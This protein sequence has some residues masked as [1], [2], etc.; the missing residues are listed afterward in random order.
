MSEYLPIQAHYHAHRLTVAG[1]AEDAFTRS[2]TSARV[3][4]NPHQVD[5]ALFA[6]K[7]PY[8]KGVLLAD[9]VGLGKTIEAGLVMSQKWAEQKQ[10]ILLV[11]PA[12]LRKQWQQELFDKFSLRSH[13]LEA[14][15]YNDLRKAG[16]TRPFEMGGGILISS[17]EFAARKAD[18]IRAVRWDL[19]VFDEAHR[20]RNVHR[21]NTAK[22]AKALKQATDGV[23]K[24]LLT[25]T[26]LQ[27][28]LMELFGI[29]S[30]ID[31]T[32]FGGENAFRAQYA[33]AATTPASQEMLRE[34]LTPICHRT[35][36]RQVQ[37]AGHINFRQ[38]NAVTFQFEPYDQETTLYEMLSEYL[39]DPG[40]IA[41]G[42]R[43][44]ALVVLQ[45]RKS[46]GSST[47][48]VARYLDTLLERLRRKQAAS[49]D[50]TDDFEDTFDEERE[51]FNG[52]NGGNDDADDFVDPVQLANE[53]ALV[54]AMRD[55]A[56]EIGVNAK[57]E[58]LIHN[59]PEVLDQIEA[60]GGRRKAV[61]FTE[62]VRTQKYLSQL[63][64]DNGYAGQIVLMNGSNNDDESRAIYNAWKERHAGTDRISGSKT[65][66]MKA[67]IVE[68]FRSDDK[69]ILIATESGAEGINL[70]F[71]SLLINYDLPW[72][73]Q[74]VEQRIGRCHR[75]G[76]LVD[77]MVVNMLN[78]K[79]R[80]EAR[81]H[82]L[83]EQKLHLFEGVF[84]SSDEVL[85]I[86]T[87]GIDFEKEVLRI[88]QSCRSAE[89]ADR[90][91]DELTSRIQ[92][93]IDTDLA[94]ARAKVLENMD[95]D[96]VAKLHR[97]NEALAQILPEFKQRLLMVAK[98]ELPDAQFPTPDSESFGWG[99]KQ[100]T[101]K[102]PLADE[103]DWQFFRVNEGLGHDLIERAKDRAVGDGAEAVRFDPAA[104]AYAGQLG[105]V[106]ALSGQSGWLRAFRAVM[107][108]PGAEREEVIVIA[109]TDA[110]EMV[111]PQVCDKMMMAPAQSLGRAA[112]DI[113]HD[114]LVQLQEFEFGHFSERV[115]QENYK[116]LIDEEERLGRYARD[117][118]I[119]IEAQIA[120]L[121][122]E[123]KEL[124]R[125]KIS[126]HLGME[127]KVTVMRDI[128]KK[129]TARDELKMSQFDAKKQV[130]KDIND[131]L[132]AF[133]ALLDE[134]PRLEEMFTLRWTVA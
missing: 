87:D 126:P 109:E 132:D 103:N 74:R 39:Q 114:R 80:A 36:R 76:Q 9:E 72:N 26:P 50:M 51:T 89:E 91:F 22:G 96:V 55:L 119:E 5:A 131:K 57:G 15:T 20:L 43:T 46:L 98:A 111:K 102:W 1:T 2:L 64:T 81:I 7:A 134:Q 69:A 107:P 92:D 11:V 120:A 130:S 94:A 49:P 82:Q 122:V 21:N 35:L 6:L 40:T 23:F 68:A 110:G 12:S 125:Q 37:E 34:R 47:F 33:G 127:E 59:L 63:L 31:D 129:E 27:N 85:G 13:I 29:V 97:R 79:N 84:G 53:I 52:D 41:Y 48:A 66:D 30:M 123:L 70:Q 25:A 24:I 95:A 62:S 83:L 56:Q 105:G 124:Q 133:S 42:G 44:N 4:M 90:E 101:T 32:H 100:W 3:E 116:W 75:Y 19:V 8:A 104:Y 118:E 93:S 67:A 16:K 86:L 113:P 58:K 108:T 77:V 14:K 10:R 65:A 38:R 88:V 60:K 121:D 18:E 61:I 128:R 112:D 54:E 115:K 17:Y 99:D 106:P 28:S 73:P 45:A 117:M 78:M 71:C